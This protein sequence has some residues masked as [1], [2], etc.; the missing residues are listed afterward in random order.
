MHRGCQSVGIV[1]V[2]LRA[3]FAT[4]ISHHQ[5][6]RTNIISSQNPL[7]NNVEK[8]Y[9]IVGTLSTTCRCADNYFEMMLKSW[10]IVGEL[11]DTSIF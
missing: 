7:E 11:G 4:K 5:N 2:Y 10:N 9:G 6:K 3:M 1:V 8:G